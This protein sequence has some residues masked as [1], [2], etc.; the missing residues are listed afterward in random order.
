MSSKAVVVLSL[1]ALAGAAAGCKKNVDV[2]PA[3]APDAQ[4]PTATKAQPVAAA[5]PVFANY[6]EPLTIEAYKDLLPQY[7]GGAFCEVVYTCPEKQM[8]KTIR[9]VAQFADRAQC[10]S[11]IGES[12]EGGNDIEAKYEATKAGRMKFDPAK[13]SA[14]LAQLKKLP[15]ECT[16][17]N[18]APTFGLAACRGVHTPLQKEDEPCKSSAECVDGL[19]CN[20]ADDETLGTC[21]PA[22]GGATPKEGESCEYLDCAPGLICQQAPGEETLKCVKYRELK[23]GERNIKNPEACAPG[24]TWKESESEC[25]KIGALADAG[26]RCDAETTACKLGLTCTDYVLDNGQAT[27][28]TCGK[29]K[30]EGAACFFS[31]ECKHG[32]ACDGYGVGPGHCRVAE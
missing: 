1:F 10:L 4:A 3:K 27:V 17:L 12:D 19:E 25:V 32:L 16:R 24:L 14:C 11:E 28:G 22:E 15:S 8:P 5:K 21:T 23:E 20:D 30:A 29:N 2:E 26:E 6:D 9:A 18:D 31:A 13:A 7:L